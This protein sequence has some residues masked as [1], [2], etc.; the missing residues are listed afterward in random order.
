MDRSKEESRGIRVGR[1]LVA[2]A[3]PSIERRSTTNYFTIAQ[4]PACTRIQSQKH[5]EKPIRPSYV[6]YSTSTVQVKEYCEQTTS[7]NNGKKK[8]ERLLL[9]LLFVS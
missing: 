3:F 7:H 9:L 5:M 1:T 6:W 2:I 8:N 4:W